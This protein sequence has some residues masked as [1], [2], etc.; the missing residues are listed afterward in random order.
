FRAG[1]GGPKRFDV[2]I[3]HILIEDGVF[4]INE[5]KLPLTL[6]ARAV[7]GR[8]VGRAERGGEGGNRLD[9]LITAQEVVTTLPRARP[10]RFT[11]SAKGSV[12]PQEG[13]VRIATARL[14][15]PDLGASASGFVDYRAAS[16]RVEL[17]IEG[18]V[19]TKTRFQWTPDGWSY[20]GT[21]SAP[22]IAALNR[23]IDDIQASFLGEAD[24]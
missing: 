10:Y 20:S 24:H 7:W 2:R 8:L 9:G 18:R 6:E 11:L 5:R 15:S 17:A 21:A 23:V 14:A 13:R 1:P 16:R 12:L 3:G 4:R 19:S 22:R